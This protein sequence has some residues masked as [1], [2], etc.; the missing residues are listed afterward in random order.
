MADEHCPT[1]GHCP[2]ACAELAGTGNRDRDGGDWKARALHAEAELNRLH[3]QFRYALS[4]VPTRCA[5]GSFVHDFKGGKVCPA[6]GFTG[7][8][9]YS[10][11]QSESEVRFDPEGLDRLT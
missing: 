11:A 8:Q 6:C 3:G 7:V 9:L 4:K 2:S 10:E 5:D 1:C